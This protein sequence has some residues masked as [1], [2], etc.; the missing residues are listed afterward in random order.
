MAVKAAA[1]WFEPSADKRVGVDTDAA[2][3]VTASALARAIMRKIKAAR[4]SEVLESG[5]PEPIHLTA[6]QIRLL[7]EHG[8][9]LAYLGPKSKILAC[10]ECGRWMIAAGTMPKK[11]S[12]SLDCAAELIK[13]VDFK[14]AKVPPDLDL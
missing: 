5:V 14:L 13:M 10:P 2:R 4:W 3:L 8:S 11:C 7:D 9:V 12:S 1:V 6:A